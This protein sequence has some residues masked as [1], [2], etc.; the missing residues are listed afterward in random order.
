[1]RA[2]DG[3]PHAILSEGNPY[4]HLVLR[5]R[6]YPS[7]GSN[8]DEESVHEAI[9]HLESADINTGVL[10][11]CSH[12]NCGGDYRRQADVARVALEHVKRGLAVRGVLIESHLRGGSVPAQGDIP[13]D[14]S[15]TDP[16]LSWEDTEAVILEWAETLR[17]L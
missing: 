1:M 15:I 6:N 8:Y 13:D 5:G 10:I 11:D 2:V 12:G 16:C 3:V 9:A 4:A 14:I 7:I 17:G